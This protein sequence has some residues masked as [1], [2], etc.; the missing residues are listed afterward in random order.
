MKCPYFF[1]ST[2]ALI[3]GS[4]STTACTAANRSRS[5]SNILEDWTLSVV[6]DEHFPVCKLCEQRNVCQCA[7][8]VLDVQICHISQLFG[9]GS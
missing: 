3:R 8:S 4:G 7:D 9:D 5:D 1:N 6:R 2:T